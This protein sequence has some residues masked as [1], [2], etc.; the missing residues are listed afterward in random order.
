MKK[1]ASI[2]CAVA[3]LAAVLASGC[4][5]A[6]PQTADPNYSV[7]AKG[8]FGAAPAV[9]IPSADADPALA[10]R[11]LIDGSGPRIGASDYLVV[12]YLDYVWRGADH[13]LISDN[14]SSPSVS[15]LT[16]LLPG[17][18]AALIGKRAGS[19]VLAV[20]PPE[21]GYGKAGM[22]A[23]GIRGSDTLVFV[24]DV[25][26]AVPEGAKA[27]GAQVFRGD[28]DLPSV[29]VSAA[30]IPTMRI[31]DAAPPGALTVRTLFKGN[32]QR[33]ENGFYILCQ[34]TGVD[35]R[36]GKVFDSSRSQEAPLGFTV[37]RAL[38]QVLPGLNQGLTGQTVGSRVM[39]ILP[40][41]DGYGKINLPPNT[42]IRSNDTVVF[43]IDII[44]AAKMLQD[45][46]ASSGIRLLAR[47]GRLGLMAAREPSPLGTP[48]VT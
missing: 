14:F 16:Q 19:R 1:L 32:G 46:S 44:G 10:V 34:Y 2:F 17:V 29:N 37:G 9:T 20:L 5:E 13:R 27:G 15:P 39:L 35:W 12:K 23:L 25:I 41:D 21:E 24:I 47:G 38:G 30:A 18:K 36:T 48:E 6:E 33:I 43:L 3:V 7:S 40:P 26:L 28:D 45:R 42:G 22:P 31:P 11:T 8:A 4:G